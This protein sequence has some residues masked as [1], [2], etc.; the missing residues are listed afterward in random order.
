M[1]MLRYPK[2]LRKHKQNESFFNL[3]KKTSAFANKYQ[4]DTATK[5]IPLC[6]VLMRK[7]NPGFI[8]HLKTHQ[9]KKKKKKTFHTLSLMRP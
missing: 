9:E 1:C 8:N 5:Q 2:N 3:R 4:S 7:Q 6:W